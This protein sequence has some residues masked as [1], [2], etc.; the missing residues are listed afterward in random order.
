[1]LAVFNSGSKVNAVHPTF[2]KELRLLVRPTDIEA[3][4]TDSIT[5]DIYGMVVTA[6]SVTD[7]SNQVRF[8]EETFLVA[9]V[10]PEVVFGML[11]LTLSSADV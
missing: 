2:A 1:M 8:F 3:Q 11:F 7:K 5:L 10:S 6:F 4:K 9:I